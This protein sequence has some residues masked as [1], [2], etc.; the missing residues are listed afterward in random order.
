MVF[1][2]NPQNKV[3][4]NGQMVINTREH[5]GIEFETAILKKI[6]GEI[7]HEKERN[8]FIFPSKKFNEKT[9]LIQNTPKTLM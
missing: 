5:S 8:E 1:S 7:F 4:E 9:E 3:P 6:D 2:L